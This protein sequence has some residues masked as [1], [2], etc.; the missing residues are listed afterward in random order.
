MAALSAARGQI[1]T[2]P[3]HYPHHKALGLP[4]TGDDTATRAATAHVRAYTKALPRA[5][6]NHFGSERRL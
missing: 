3:I 4:R 1:L 6:A 5:Q 2:R